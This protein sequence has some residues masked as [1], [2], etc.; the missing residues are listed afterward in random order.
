MAQHARL[1]VDAHDQIR[2][3]MPLAAR[4]QREHQR[5]AASVLPKGTDLSMYSPETLAAVA[6]TLD[7]Q[8]GQNTALENAEGLD[9][10]LAEIEKS[11]LP[12]PAEIAQVMPESMMERVAPC[13][14]AL[15]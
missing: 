5:V 6:A 14:P 7:G 1:K 10:C 11:E 13:P 3:A 15:F 9:Q 8:A 12:R 4:H 2:S